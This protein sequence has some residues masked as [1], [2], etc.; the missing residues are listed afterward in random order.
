MFQ[1]P[2]AGRVA[3]SITVAT[4][5]VPSS[6]WFAPPEKKTSVFEYP[7]IYSNLANVVA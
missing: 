3:P 2:Y 6:L 7:A 4:E 1:G 5:L